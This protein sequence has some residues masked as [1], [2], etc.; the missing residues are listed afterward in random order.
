MNEQESLD[1]LSNLANLDNLT[2]LAQFDREYPTT[3]EECLIDPIGPCEEIS[4]N[5]FTKPLDTF[6][7]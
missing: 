1:E 7:R 3:F 6:I 5:H 4:P 2:N